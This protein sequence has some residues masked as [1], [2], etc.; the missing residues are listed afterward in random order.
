MGGAGAGPFGGAAARGGDAGDEVGDVADGGGAGQ[1]PLAALAAGVRRDRAGEAELRRL[2][3][4]RGACA[5]GRIAP[6][7][8]TSPK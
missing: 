4:P 8:P 2:L 1:R 7:S 6:D 3:Q 5:T